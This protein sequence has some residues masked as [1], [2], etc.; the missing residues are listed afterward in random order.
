MEEESD[1]GNY[2]ETVKPLSRH[3]ELNEM[4]CFLEIED[5]TSDNIRLIG[6]VNGHLMNC[7]ECVII[8]EKYKKLQQK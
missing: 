6:R 5:L 8:F 2:I 7:R 1:R 3:L 4:K